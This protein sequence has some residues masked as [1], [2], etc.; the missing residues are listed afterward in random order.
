MK[1]PETIHLQVCDDS[2][3]EWCGEITW[4]EDRVHEEDV[5]YI[6]ADILKPVL[7]AIEALTDQEDNMPAQTGEFNDL[8]AALITLRKVMTL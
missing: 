1:T 2:M 8:K 3:S 5:K 4:C 6:R 7:A